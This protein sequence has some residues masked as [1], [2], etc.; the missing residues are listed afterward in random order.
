M[1]DGAVDV[2]WG[3]PDGI[4]ATFRI[5]RERDRRVMLYFLLEHGTVTVGEIADVVTGWSAAMDGRVATEAD[6]R[7]T[8][9]ELTARHLPMMA[10]ASLVSHDVSTASIGL[11]DPPEL[12]QTAL[13]TTI[14]HETERVTG[15]G[16]CGR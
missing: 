7:R 4:D 11:L 9:T 15:R 5:L 8:R 13:R 6:W 14:E 1:E 16:G 3:H 10:E 12:V 2:D